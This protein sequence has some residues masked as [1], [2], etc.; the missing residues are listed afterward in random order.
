MLI[1]S[2]SDIVGEVE[3]PA[4]TAKSGGV[5]T[6]GRVRSSLTGGVDDV[7]IPASAADSAGVATAGR[8]RSSVAAGVGL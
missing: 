2:S 8:V 5:A 3:I 6:G 4:S 1:Q 7:E